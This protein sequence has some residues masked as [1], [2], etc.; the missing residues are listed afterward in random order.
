MKR[1]ATVFFIAVVCMCFFIVPRAS[2]KDASDSSVIATPVDYVLPYPGILAD[3]PLYIVKNFRDKIMEFL[4]ADP[5]KKVQF[6]ILQSDKDVNASIFLA[7]K[8]KGALALDSLTWANKTTG[9]AIPLAESLKTQ[10]RDLPAYVV[11]QLQTSLAKHEE[12]VRD[13]VGGVPA[14]AQKTGY[15]NAIEVIQGFAAKIADLK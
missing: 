14:D 2:A 9:K 8:G 6:Y 1:I 15:E 5:V 10:G 12:V 11:E 7:A 13:L 3:N 4:I